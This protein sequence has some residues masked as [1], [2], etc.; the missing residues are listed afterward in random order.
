MMWIDVFYGLL[1][2]NIVWFVINLVL[3]L[4]Q[5]IWHPASLKIIVPKLWM[6]FA[7]S[8]LI[9]LGICWIGL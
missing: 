6:G 9:H 2:F 7:C 4:V 8:L 5:T 1:C 3:S